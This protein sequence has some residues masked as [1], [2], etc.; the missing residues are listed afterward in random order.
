MKWKPTFRLSLRDTNFV[1]NSKSPDLNICMQ[2]LSKP[3]SN[4]NFQGAK[5]K[6]RAPFFVDAMDR[7]ETQTESGLVPEKSQTL[8]N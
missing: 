3:M 4:G 8:P 7:K 2:L 1:K 5:V 6:I